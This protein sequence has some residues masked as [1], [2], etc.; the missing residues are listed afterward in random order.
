M[1]ASLH[2]ARTVHR[3]GASLLVAMAESTMYPCIVT[4]MP[5]HIAM[6]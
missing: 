5:G 1:T 6:L 2:E 4:E 3:H